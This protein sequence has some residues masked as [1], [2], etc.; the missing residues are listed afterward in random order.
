MNQDVEV[1]KLK[2]YTEVLCRKNNMA[3][4][5]ENWRRINQKGRW[6]QII[7]DIQKLVNLGKRTNW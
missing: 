1:G 5:E 2:A 3:K 6:G 4:R 7:K